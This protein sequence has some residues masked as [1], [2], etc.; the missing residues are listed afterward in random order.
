M[1]EES[2]V[3]RPGKAARQ[4]I[5]DKGETLEA[6]EGWELLPP[7]DA[8]LTRRV[9]KAGPHWQVQEKRGRKL[10]SRGVWAPA[11]TIGS[12]R[13]VLERERETPAY[14]KKRASDKARREKEQVSYVEDFKGAV[15]AFLRFHPRYQGLAEELATAVT[16]HASPVGSGTVARTRRIP[17]EERASAAVIAWLRH[18][19]TAYDNLR[20]A[21]VKGE[22]RRVRRRLAKESESL[23][24]AYRRGEVL[25]AS[26][27]E[28]ALAKNR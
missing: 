6:P 11:E 2:R 12:L 19:T 10:F 17:I 16:A 1:P 27:L 18:Q 25:D 26:P 20:I 28:Q 21:R 13:D 23:L 15:L 24:E 4:V 8:A 9:K 7:G 5:S 14:K 3:V 22:R